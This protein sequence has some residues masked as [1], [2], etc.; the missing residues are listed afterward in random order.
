MFTS[1]FETS[2]VHGS[3]RTLQNTSIF[4]IEQPHPMF[5]SNYFVPKYFKKQGGA[6]GLFS[7]QTSLLILG[8]SSLR[9]VMVSAKRRGSKAEMMLWWHAQTQEAFESHLKAAIIPATGRTERLEAALIW[10]AMHQ[11]S[12]FI[13]NTP[14]LTKSFQEL[15]YIR[16][17]NN[18]QHIKYSGCF[19]KHSIRKV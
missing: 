12:S 2:T 5:S 10:M 15:T 7:W 3:N 17:V 19:I 18:L 13:S 8:Y 1:W 14:L 6:V 9:D 4:T 16:E 11:S